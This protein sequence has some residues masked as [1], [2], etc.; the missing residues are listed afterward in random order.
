MGSALGERAIPV[1]GR[2]SELDR[3]G[4]AID[5][6]ADRRPCAWFVHG[7]LGV[8]KTRLVWEVCERA[9]DRGFTVLWGRCVRFGAATSPY[10][11]LVGPVEDW[12]ATTDEQTRQQV[13]AE[14]ESVAAESQEPT[15]TSR[16]LRV[17]ERIFARIEE[18][19]PVVLVV[20]D[21]QWADVTSLD[22]LAYLVAGFRHQRMAV[23]VT[24][25]DTELAE[26]H[27]LH[28][29]VADLRRLPAVH[30]LPLA[31]FDE[32]GTEEQLRALIGHIPSGRLVEEVH[33]RSVG[34]PYLTE[35]LV[36]DLPPGADS[37]P[38]GLP[39]GLREVLLASWH[40]LGAHAR[41]VLRLLAV[42]GR[43][44]PYA[45]FAAVAD[46]LGHDPGTVAS[47]LAEGTRSGVLQVEKGNGYWFRHPL[48]AEVLTGTLLPGEGTALHAAF[49]EVLRGLEARDE[50]EEMR[51]LSDLSLH[52]EG[53]AKPDEAFAFTMRAAE[54]AARL[55]GYPEQARQLLRAVDLLPDVR[56]SVIEET[57][58]GELAL[59]ER[60]AFACSRSGELSAAHQ[61]VTRGLARVNRARDELLAT[62]LLIEWCELM[63]N[64]RMVERQPL[65]RLIEA[66]ELSEVA[67]HSEEHA[68]ALARLAEAE[69]SCGMRDA[70]EEHVRQAVAAA[71]RSG[72]SSA[73]A[74]TLS[75]RA[76]VHLREPSATADS[77]DAY[78]WARRS[79]DPVVVAEACTA[80]VRCLEEQGQVLEVL[81]V[82]AEGFAVATATGSRAYQ[83][84]FAGQAAMDSLRLGRFADA[85]TWVREGLAARSVGHGAVQVRRAAA[86]LAIREGRNAEAAEHIERILEL[87]P[88]FESHVAGYGPMLLAEY[89]LALGQPDKALSQVEAPLVTHA[90]AGPREADLLLLWAVRAAGDLAR[91]GRD[92]GDQATAESARRR[93]QRLEEY[94]SA[95]GQPLF[96]ASGPHDLVGP[97]VGAVF[98]AERSR[99]DGSS[100]EVA[101]WRA[102]V[103][104]C[105]AAGLR[106]EAAVARRWL[107]EALLD[108]GAPRSAVSRAL[109]GA[110]DAALRMGAVPLREDVETLARGA[111]I[112]LS[113]PVAADVDNDSSLLRHLT[114]RERE[115]LAQLVTGRSYAEIAE[116][117]FISDKTVSVHVSNILRKTGARNRNEV[118]AL[119]RRHGVGR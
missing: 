14:L 106:W 45:T 89:H 60:A 44:L 29:W 104:R 76:L 19:S 6:M 5:G 25:R 80:R 17:V 68:I 92:A 30:D 112:D 27:P 95:G 37:L 7:E 96:L 15:R 93:L 117:L 16:V 2:H 4:K 36:H 9:S 18:R 66:V 11:P 99:V 72:S 41:E 65:A 43:P 40:G 38:P 42:G 55:Q 54:Y 91:A 46:V 103:E 47:A 111:R 61:L 109:R 21:L 24:F 69:W 59:L 108:E 10:A 90:P 113:Q 32:S 34:N 13:R 75:V 78:T 62:R 102:A 115:V 35:L 1:V 53:S 26:G 105:E 85:R 73:M 20:D 67:P 97:A 23:L 116:E 51:L 100:G 110:H 74:V 3:L 84:H 87:S 50:A 33:A 94:R 71:E 98:E 88:T 31:R 81:A 28:G 79:K 49:V 86:A 119:G 58:G 82:E 48:L 39:G 70:G 22:L 57:V 52:H 12:L 101:R 114:R 64:H 77:E 8:G 63:W 83:A 107:G 118:A 56:P